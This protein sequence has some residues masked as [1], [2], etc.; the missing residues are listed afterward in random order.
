MKKSDLYAEGARLPEQLSRLLFLEGMVAGRR[1]LEV[2]ATSPA[3]ARFLLDLGATRVVC[4]V[5][6]AAT[7]LLDGLRN[8]NDVDKIDFRAIRVPPGSRPPGV[9]AVPGPRRLSTL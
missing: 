2:G 1:V 9:Q 5:D 4:A 8:R 3:V 7:G 6:P